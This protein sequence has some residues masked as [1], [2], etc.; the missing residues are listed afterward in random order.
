MSSSTFC[1][2]EFLLYDLE[3]G[4][5]PSVNFI[6]ILSANF[7]YKSAASSFSLIT[8]WLCNFLAQKYWPGSYP[9]KFKSVTEKKHFKLGS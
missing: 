6:N 5:C 9:I 4:K 1:W 8:F 2:T 7:L 3:I